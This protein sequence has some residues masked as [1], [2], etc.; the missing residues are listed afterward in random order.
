[1]AVREDSALRRQ[2]W[3]PTLVVAWVVAV[4]V[5]AFLLTSGAS[6][7]TA[8]HRSGSAHSTRAGDSRFASDNEAAE[9]QYVRH[10]RH[11]HR[12]QISRQE[13]EFVSS[14]PSPTTKAG[15]PFTGE[16]VLEVVALGLLFAGGGLLIAR[17][18]RRRT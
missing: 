18:V 5:L 12:G 14:A 17:R 9:A 6:G 2:R 7:S 11:Q 10:T 13:A 15:L 1:M 8:R 3:R 4:G 16:N